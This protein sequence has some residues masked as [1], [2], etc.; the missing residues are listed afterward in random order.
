[1]FFLTQGIDTIRHTS[2]FQGHFDLETPLMIV[3]ELPLNTGRAIR[4]V[5]VGLVSWVA[6]KTLVS[7]FVAFVF[8]LALG[9]ASFAWDRSPTDTLGIYAVALLT[10]LAAAFGSWQIAS[11]DLD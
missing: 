8:A 3:T 2:R 4:W 11:L 1:M 10:G 5:R 6:C 9:A 7:F